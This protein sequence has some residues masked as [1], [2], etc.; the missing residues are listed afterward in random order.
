MT[1]IFLIV[2]ICIVVGLVLFLTTRTVFFL[3]YR[4]RHLV[5]S[6]T[7]LGCG[8]RYADGRIGIGCGRI[9][10]YFKP[11]TEE[12]RK[13]K[14]DKKA[15]RAAAKKEKKPK[16][17]RRMKLGVI[18]RI[19]KA[20][21]LFVVDMLSRVRYDGGELTAV[22]VIADPAIAGMAFG[23]GQA[24]YG[25]FPELRRTIDVIPTYGQEKSRLSGHFAVSFPNR[26]IIVPVWRLLRNLPI[27]EL[28]RHR[29]SGRGG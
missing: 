11:S 24:F 26:G 17:G 28:I 4:E 8:I 27:I 16:K 21:F 19:A 18:L 25:M 15:K 9:V 29:F 5:A 10:H 3:L 22:P 1:I 7:I 2:A 14:K 13:K 6:L 20:L 23:W 12:S